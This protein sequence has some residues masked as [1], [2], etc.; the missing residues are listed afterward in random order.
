[1]SFG[2]VIQQESS[3]L[4]SRDRYTEYMVGRERVSENMLWE[5]QGGAEGWLM[6]RKMK[7]EKDG[8]HFRSWCLSLWEGKGWGGDRNIDFQVLTWDSVATGN[9]VI[10][11]ET[12]LLPSVSHSEL[13]ESLLQPRGPAEGHKPSPDSTRVSGKLKLF[14]SIIPF[15][16]RGGKNERE[17]TK[18]RKERRT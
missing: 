2:Q 1:M 11:H 18:E 9:S 7:G 6:G 5:D 16:T 3:I 4:R 10:T 15:R 13:A 8:W 17:A 12:R 14:L